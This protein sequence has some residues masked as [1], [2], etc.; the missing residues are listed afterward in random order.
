MR[1]RKLEQKTK[2]RRKKNKKINS[3]IEI[4]VSRIYEREIE[5]WTCNKTQ[6]NVGFLENVV[7]SFRTSRL[8]SNFKNLATRSI[9]KCQIT[10]KTHFSENLTVDF[11]VHSQQK[12]RTENFVKIDSRMKFSSSEPSCERFRRLNRVGPSLRK[13]F[14][15]F[16]H[17]F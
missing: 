1:Q 10:P 4:L 5:F 14:S 17:L 7:S 16:L 11:V 15:T 13:L 8:S 9:L 2:S 12:T 6:K 3:K